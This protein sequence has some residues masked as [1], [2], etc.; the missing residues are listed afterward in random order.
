MPTRRGQRP[1]RPAP[2]PRSKLLAF[3]SLAL[4]KLGSLIGTRLA[5]WGNWVVWPMV[6]ASSADSAAS[7][8]S[9]HCSVQPTSFASST[10]CQS[11]PFTGTSS[12][13]KE[14]WDARPM[15]VTSNAGCVETIHSRTSPAPQKQLTSI[16][17]PGSTA[18]VAE[19]FEVMQTPPTPQTGRDDACFQVRIPNRPSFGTTVV[20]VAEGSVAVQMECTRSAASAAAVPSLQC[21][22]RL[23]A[24]TPVSLQA[25]AR[26]AQ[27]KQVSP[28]P[29]A[30]RQELEGIRSQAPTALPAVA[31]V[32]THLPATKSCTMA[33]QRMPQMA[34]QTVKQATHL[35]R[36]KARTTASA[37]MK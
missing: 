11:P 26:V 7:T 31:K 13:K 24:A 29:P 30:T 21:L 16:R 19:S 34:M 8:S 5:R 18:M 37:R 10:A 15:V 3:G 17:Q 27:P 12:A 32:K 33:A 6:T 25:P 9:P 28:Q 35:T 1:A 2:C 23:Q 4:S 36:A 14:C 22:A 20:L